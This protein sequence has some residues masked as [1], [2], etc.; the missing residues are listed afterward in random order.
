MVEEING[1]V[2]SSA[3]FIPTRLS[4]QGHEVYHELL[5]A[6]ASNGTEQTLAAKLRDKGLMKTSEMRRN[7]LG[8]SKTPVP[9]NAA[10]ILA[11]AEFNKFYVRAMCLIAAESGGTQVEVYRAQVVAESSAEVELGIGRKVD[12]ARLLADLRNSVDLDSALGL[13]SGRHSGLSVTPVGAAQ[14]V[15]RAEA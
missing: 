8:V 10:E 12:A 14:P 4:P 6:A 9:A 1:D 5:K 3:L 2:A 7:K 15:A 13:S 11:D